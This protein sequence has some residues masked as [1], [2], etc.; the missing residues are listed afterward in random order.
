M[1]D[2]KIAGGLGNQ[3]FQYA[4]YIRLKKEY[5]TLLFR[6]DYDSYKYV[7]Y[8]GGFKLNKIFNIPE[9]I[10]LKDKYSIGERLFYRVKVKAK[11]YYY[12][13]INE[14]IIKDNCNLFDFKL[15]SNSYSYIIGTWA[16]ERCF[17]QAKKEILDLYKF[18][19]NSLSE[20]TLRK[21]CAIAN[22]PKKTVAIH[23]RRGDYVNS[24]FI[25]LAETN[26]YL[27]SLEY[28][29]RLE[30]N[31]LKLYIFSDNPQWC[32]ENLPFL[33]QFEYEFNIGKKDYEDMYLISRCMYIIIANSTFSWWSA[34]LSNASLVIAP[35]LHMIGQ[36]KPASYPKGWL[37]MKLE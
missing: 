25:P 22:C 33:D 19:P 11:E 13:H 2:I 12:S 3:M 26:Y 23:I 35:Q 4:L 17:I 28:I 9:S 31:N 1:I 29:R 15:V 32:K 27:N 5:P 24:K 16:D 18:S 21:S 6:L 7:D 36:T 8:H 14:R 37:V 34:Y 20:E 10:S 30:N